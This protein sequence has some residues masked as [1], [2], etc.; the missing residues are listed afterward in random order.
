MN[1][2]RLLAV[3]ALLAAGPVA[4]AEFI[5]SMPDAAAHAGA[6][7][8]IDLVILNDSDA[9]LRFDLPAQLHA[10]LETSTSASTLAL[11]PDRSGTLE[12]AP[13]QFLRVALKGDVPDAAPD[14]AT[15]TL[16]DLTTNRLVLRIEAQEQSGTALIDKP[17]PPVRD[18]LSAVGRDTRNW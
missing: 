8:R 18:L 13:R 16:S 15:L 1:L 12:V 9:P 5:L 4:R 6:P 10:R 7:L 2:I 11:A 3:A 14:T 17:P